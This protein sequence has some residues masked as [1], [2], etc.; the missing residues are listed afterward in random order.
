MDVLLEVLLSNIAVATALTVLAVILGRFGCRPSVV[1]VLC[2]LALLKL[3]TPPM[4]RLP[5]LPV[6]DLGTTVATAAE[7]ES[8]TTTAKAEVTRP[9]L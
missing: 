3:V 9:L 6:L 5:I 2:V 1:H 4:F 8:K 7:T